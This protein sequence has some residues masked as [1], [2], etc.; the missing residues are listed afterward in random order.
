MQLDEGACTRC[1][2]AEISVEGRAADGSRQQCIPPQNENKT[3]TTLAKWTPFREL[4][5]LQKRLGSL[6]GRGPLLGNSGEAM[7][8]AEWAPAV[9]VTEDEKEYLIK[10]EL[11]DVKKEDVKVTVEDGTLRITGERKFE[12]EEK[13]KKYHRIESSYGRFERAFTVPDNT[14]AD[15]LTAEYK[16]G[17]LRV[18]LPKSETAKPKQVEVKVA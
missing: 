12:K 4:D 2:F 3:M 1:K 16:E 14:K 13:G 11:P 9:D 10:A 8:V 17:V 5:D 6:F 18:H 15:A 7:A